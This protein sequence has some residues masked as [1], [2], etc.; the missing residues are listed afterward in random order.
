M[1]LLLLSFNR[2][3]HLHLFYRDEERSVSFIIIF[4]FFVIAVVTVLIDV[5]LWLISVFSC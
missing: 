4:L 3:V 1:L 2:Y 5:V